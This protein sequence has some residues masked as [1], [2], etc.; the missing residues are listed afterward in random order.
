MTHFRER[1]SVLPPEGGSH[2]TRHS[3]RSAFIGEI[4]A[5]RAAGM[6][7]ARN[8]HAASESAAMDVIEIRK[9]AECLIPPYY[10]RD[11]ALGE[12]LLR[13]TLTAC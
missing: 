3:A 12:A 5:A 4:D 2:G 9:E 7:A 10:R 13:A 11:A 8:A 1:V 6:I